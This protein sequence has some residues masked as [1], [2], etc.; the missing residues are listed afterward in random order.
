[1][2]TGRPRALRCFLLMALLV[3]AACNRTIENRLNELQKLTVPSGGDIS[4][5]TGLSRSG[6]SATARWGLKAA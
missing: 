2:S 6:M 3:V 4:D 1:M 5:Y